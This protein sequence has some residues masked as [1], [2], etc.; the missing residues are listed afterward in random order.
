MNV[1]LPILLLVIGGLTF[2]LLV[3]ST[4]KY[5]LKIACIASFCLFT[6]IFW[7]SIHSFLGWAALE[8]DMPEKVLIH[9]TIIKEPNK[10]I[11]FDGRI[12]ILLESAKGDDDSFLARLFGYRKEKIEPRLFALEYSRSLHEKLEGIKGRLTKGQPVLGELKKKKGDKKGIGSGKEK[13]K[14]NDGEGSESQEQDWEFH[15]LQP[16]DLHIKD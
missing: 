14:G 1:A 5:Y 6:V 8:D 4:V 10:T 11:E 15:E 2:W 16:S 13:S 9:W 12:Y 7:G 3:E